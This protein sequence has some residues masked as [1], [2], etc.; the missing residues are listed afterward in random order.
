MPD[1][2]YNIEFF[3]GS[4]FS[5]NLTVKNSNGSLK[6]LS[7][8]SARMQIRQSYGS[9]SATESLTTSNGEIVINTTTST[10]SL[11]LSAERTANIYVDL[12]GSGSPPKTKYVYDIELVNNSDNSVSKLLFGD[13]M[14]YGE[15][16]R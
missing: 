7:S 3:Q 8:H 10:M 16:T 1:N 14:V 5:L 4:T 9:G 6:D 13:V 2:K 15:V 12:N 11:V